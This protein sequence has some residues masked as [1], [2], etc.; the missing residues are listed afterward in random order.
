MSNDAKQLDFQE[1]L[2]KEIQNKYQEKKRVEKMVEEEIEKEKTNVYKSNYK[3][4]KLSAE[5]I[6][7]IKK[8]LSQYTTDELES[9]RINTLNLFEEHDDFFI[10]LYTSGGKRKKS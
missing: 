1:E 4:I 2:T 7:V 9:E 6:V 5:N 8:A 3:K 10:V